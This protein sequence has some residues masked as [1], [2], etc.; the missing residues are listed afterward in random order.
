MSSRCREVV[1]GLLLAAGIGCGPALR[2]GEPVAALRVCAD[3]QN[4]PYSNADE[5]GFEN[6]IARVLADELRAPLRFAWEPQGRGF[7][8]KTI[9]AGLCD[10]FIGVP[11]GFERVATTR[12]YYRS[13]YVFV[14]RA[15]AARPLVS[16]DDPRL[17]T[18]TV[19]VQLVGDDLAATPPGHALAHRAAHVVGYPVYGDGPAAA[20][21]VDDLAAG[22]ID[23]A[24][25]WG[26]QAGW[27]A[28]R[29]A[30]P[31]RLAPAQAPADLEAMP[32]DYSIAVGV[33]RGDAELLR[34][35]DAAL[36]RR[37]AD[38]AAILDA[39]AVPRLALRAGPVPLAGRG[40]GDDAGG[41]LR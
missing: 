41:V 11:V 39:Y 7:V 31:L 32:F 16:F 13:G 14:N 20:R 22:R 33:R 1:A 38:I 17:A 6:R 8:R 9:G 5:S 4:L 24:L 37:T 2:A 15:D 25:L 26:P 27:F 3:P 18:L 28:A 34:A 36:A 40:G 29:S 12:P 21:A 23:A 19:G 30:V 35:L 10:V